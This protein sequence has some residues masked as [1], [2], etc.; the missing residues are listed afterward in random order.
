[1]TRS[2]SGFTLI[3]LLVSAVLMALVSA[4][5]ATV[6][7]AGLGV[8]AA[9]QD[10]AGLS[11]A[12]EAVT[13]TVARDLRNAFR[14]GTAATSA[15]AGWFLV[16]NSDDGD[17]RSYMEL[18]TLS[19][20]TQ[21]LAYLAAHDASATENMSDQAHVIYF[22]VP[23]A[24]GETYELHR[25]EICPPGSEIGS[26]TPGLPLNEEDRETGATTLLCDGV[27]SFGLRFWDG[28]QQDDW[29]TTWD[30]ITAGSTTSGSLPV[31]AEIELVM[32]EGRRQH[33]CFTRVPIRMG[34]SS[35]G[36]GA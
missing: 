11:Q 7:S 36:S 27:V 8:W 29:V 12:T 35:S 14:E 33:S 1:M 5:V 4:G 34:Q 25:Q 30:S 22:L 3:E 19:R 28:Q 32:R 9:G 2:R 15:A 16:A 13:D 6:M 18:T 26:S 23:A 21:R 17:G 31:A 20:R 10:R 24:D